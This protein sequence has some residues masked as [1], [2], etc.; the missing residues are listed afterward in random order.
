MLGFYPSMVKALDLRLDFGKYPVGRGRKAVSQLRHS[1]SFCK[2]GE[3]ILDETWR[4]DNAMVLAGSG[5]KRP[6][7]RPSRL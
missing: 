2:L 4:L 5:T 3:I 7:A 1:S 6:G